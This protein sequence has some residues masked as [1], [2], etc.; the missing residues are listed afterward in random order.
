[1]KLYKYKTTDYLQD[2]I[3]NK[4]LYCSKFNELND[5]MEWAFV[6]DPNMKDQIKK[7]INGN[8]KEYYRI[9]CLSRSKQY[10]LMWS[11]YAKDHK[12]VCLEIE[13]DESDDSVFQKLSNENH[14]DSSKWTWSDIQYKSKA[15]N[16]EN[17]NCQN[18][19]RF[20][21]ETF[22]WTKS[23]QWEHEQEV[24]FVRRYDNKGP[25]FMPI[26]IVSVYLGKRM[27]ENEARN[28][29]M[30]C[31]AFDVKCID[32]KDENAPNINYWARSQCEG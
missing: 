12:G 23:V 27:D 13:I 15:D 16:L 28:I 19:N 5:P 11:M 7:L 1:M 2:I 9:C 24:R 25:Q 10:G 4:H 20:K 3:I 18:G 26:R 6:A 8:Q 17:D 31:A 22:L 14:V 30:L 21:L 32:M 29:K